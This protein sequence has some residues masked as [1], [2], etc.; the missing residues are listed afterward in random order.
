MRQE[1]RDGNDNQRVWL[2]IQTAKKPVKLNICCWL[3]GEERRRVG[4]DVE[5]PADELYTAE[6]GGQSELFTSSRGGHANAQ[7]KWMSRFL[8]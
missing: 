1:T 5:V 4:G 8:R 6:L 3:R 7:L 2:W